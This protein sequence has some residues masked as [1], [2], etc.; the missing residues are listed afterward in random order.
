MATIQVRRFSSAQQLLEECR[1][2]LL[3]EEV[4][5][6]LIL[7]VAQRF[8]DQG[9]AAQ[10]SL[11]AA[12]VKLGV[13]R[14][15]LGFQAP[16]RPLMLASPA[17][18]EALDPL[19]EEWARSLAGTS[20]VA[21]HRIVGEPALARVVAESAARI[22]P[23]GGSVQSAHEMQIL[24][25]QSAP[26]LKAPVGG[27]SRLATEDEIPQ[28]IRWG[29]GFARDAG[30]SNTQEQVAATFTLA[31]QRGEIFVWED[32]GELRSMCRLSQTG[33]GSA[34]ISAVYTPP[35]ERGQ[36]YGSA[37]VAGVT[38]MALSKGSHAVTLYVE[39]PEVRRLY[40]RIGFTL[41]CE[42]TEYQIIPS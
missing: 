33:T 37:I 40:E 24:R 6:S 11:F 2:W 8:A 21:S 3:Q 29:V 10:T 35:A 26:A 36:G 14:L 20:T 13:T 18:P 27:T 23:G 34:R 22:L 4:A 12:E 38:E 25:I 41:A 30:L 42:A 5:N 31:V 16:G 17:L 39:K 1:E 15:A 9:A 28:I 7:S 19:A 32:I